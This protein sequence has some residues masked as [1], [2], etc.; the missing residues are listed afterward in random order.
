MSWVSEFL[1]MF[2]YGFMINAMIAG[3]IIAIICP[4]IGNFLVLKKYSMIGDTLSHSALA[5]VAIGLLIS[6]DPLI[7]V[8]SA[9]VFTIIC[10]IFLEKLR[11]YYK[12]LAEMT[13]AIVLTLSVGIAITI[14]SKANLNANI[15]SYLFGSIITVGTT[16]L[17]VIAGLGIIT[18]IMTFLLY[19]KLLFITFDEVGARLS[20]IN[21]D[22][23]NYIFAALTAVTIAISIRITGMLVISSL[24]VLPVAS[25]MQVSKSFKNTMLISVVVALIDVTIGL[26]SSYFGDCAPGGAIALMSV[27][28][29]VIFIVI[30]KVFS[31]K[32]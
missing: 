6:S 11:Q 27:F 5:G 22:R 17:Y 20:G 32:N 9:V 8:I 12:Q 30:N 24:I 16:D 13:M 14:I 4:L 19:N 28:V 31:I 2:Q 7:P 10:S 3:I 25:A 29:M 1:S 15:T 23:V 26:I 21:V 18:I